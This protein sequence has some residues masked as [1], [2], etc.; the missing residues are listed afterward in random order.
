MDNI[1]VGTLPVWAQVLATLIPILAAA[2]ALMKGYGKGGATPS[3]SN[4]TMQVIG[5]ALAER[6][7]TEGLTE[8]IRSIHDAI[9]DSTKE[10]SRFRKSLEDHTESVVREHERLREEAAGIRR[11]VSRQDNPE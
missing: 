5:G 10:M 8:A 9:Q 3:Q 4:A 1:D 6:Y 11:R 2:Y 7:A